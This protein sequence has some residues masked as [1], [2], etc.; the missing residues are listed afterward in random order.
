MAKIAIM[1]QVLQLF[2][3]KLGFKDKTQQKNRW[4]SLCTASECWKWDVKVSL[5]RLFFLIGNWVNCLLQL[6]N[7]A[8]QNRQTGEQMSH[9]DM[10]KKA[11]KFEF[12]LFN[13]FQYVICSPVWRFCSTWLLSCK[14][15]IWQPS[16]MSSCYHQRAIVHSKY[17]DKLT[18]LLKERSVKNTWNSVPFT[19]LSSVR[20][21]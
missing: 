14:R 12:S 10:L 15:P 6:S 17:D 20:P 8:V 4:I 21:L 18:T 19:L 9:W 1:W 13:M 2:F 16:A 11:T 5:I 3:P 7:E